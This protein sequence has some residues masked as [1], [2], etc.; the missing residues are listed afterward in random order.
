MNKQIR[1]LLIGKGLWGTNWYK[2]LFRKGI[3]FSVVDKM[4]KNCVDDRHILNYNTLEQ[5]LDQQSF[6]HAI[7][8]T[9]SENHL[10]IFESLET[11]IP[12]EQILIEKPCGASAIDFEK[13]GKFFPGYLFLYSEPYKYIKEHLNKIGIPVMYRSTRAAMGPQPRTDVTVVAD[14]LIHDLYIF[15]D[16]F[17]FENITVEGASLTRLFT[18]SNLPDTVT[19]QLN[20]IAPRPIFADMFSSWWYPYKQREVIIAGTEGT[21]LWINDT[22][23]FV[24]NAFRKT[25]SVDRRGFHRYDLFHSDGRDI[26][27]TEKMTLDC[28]LDFFLSG[29]TPNIRPSQ[30]WDLIEK[31]EQY[32]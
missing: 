7:I 10:E 32:E 12:N 9:P 6:T 1:I 18:H 13:K 22:L 3:D 4:L 8:A 24:E 27:L 21:F 30:V 31:I 17:G 14:Y 5:A 25:Q 29:Q 26:I 2:T 28:E 16:L 11:I 20:N 15:A 23:R 19:V